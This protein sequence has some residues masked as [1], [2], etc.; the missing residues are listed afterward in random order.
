MKNFLLAAFAAI[1]ALI[2]S[3]DEPRPCRVS[4][5]SQPEGAS[6]IID[7]KDRGTTPI[8]LFDLAPGR[9]H[10]KLRRAG[11]VEC[12]RFFNTG[13][14]PYVEK[15]EVLDEVK[16]I[17]LIKSEPEGAN[18][19]IDGVS[20]GQTPRLITTLSAKDVYG[21]KL[22]KAGYQ[23]Q[24]L[25]VRF[26]GRKPLVRE[27]KLVLASGV[28]DIMSEPAG[29]EVTVNGISRGQT[30]VKVSGIPKGLATVVFKMK[31]FA[32]KTLEL[33]V[34]AGDVQTLSTALERLPGTLHLISVP[35][36]ARF[37]LNGEARGKGPLAITGLTPGD[38]RVR[39]ELDGFGTSERT[40]TIGN[41]E[42][43]REEFKLSNVM[44]RLEIRTSPP[45]SQI[46][47]DGRILGV[48]KAQSEKDE[49]SAVFPIDNVLEGEHSLVVK[50]DGYA[51][52]VRHPKI[53]NSKT[54]VANV[55]LRRIFTPNVEIVTARGEYRG[56]LVSRT[57]N[58]VVLEVS[59]GITRSFPQEEIR[60]FTWLD[61]KK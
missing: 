7:G 46:I 58:E 24:S 41:G 45:G 26:E 35:E 38:Y 14:V 2:L 8:T 40:I 60:K 47:F 16:G 61:G 51:E 50:K 10:L 13:E 12:D 3:A 44:G 33:R 25:S 59:L 54:S 55:R 36:G 22:R 23:D 21:V 56:V 48:T 20:Y 31:G 57:P 29:A 30:P 28:V 5:T 39:A 43:A 34:N 49:F 19:L 27:E 37:Y 52:S 42:S 17:L 4:I 11:Y 18:I 53:R 15:S 6:V 1:A 9:H 32:D